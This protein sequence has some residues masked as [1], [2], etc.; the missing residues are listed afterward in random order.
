MTGP[1]SKPRPRR[2]EL[3]R[4]TAFYRIYLFEEEYFHPFFK[5]LDPPA[6]QV[7]A[8]LQ[9]RASGLSKFNSDWVHSYRRGQSESSFIHH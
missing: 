5:I 9:K 3:S 2:P 8:A 7:V 6:D 4:W 1:L